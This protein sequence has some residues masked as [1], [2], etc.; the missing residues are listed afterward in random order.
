MV[1]AGLVRRPADLDALETWLAPVAGSTLID[2][3]SVHVYPKAAD[4]PQLPDLLAQARERLV[5]SGFG[6]VP[7]WVTEVNVQDGS[8]MADPEQGSAV[9]DLTAQVEEAGFARAYWYA[10]TDL[11]PL[12]L[13]QLAPGTVGARSLASR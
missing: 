4:L 3:V 12:N 11:G 8:S 13:I 9:G 10:W 2:A 1:N 6:G 7:L 5:A